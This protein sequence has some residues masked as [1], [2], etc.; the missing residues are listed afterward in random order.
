MRTLL[1]TLF[2]LG[3]LTI[4]AAVPACT[5][6]GIHAGNHHTG[7]YPS[8]AP[9]VPAGSPPGVVI[10]TCTGTTSDATILQRAI[11]SSPFGATIEIGGGTCLLNKG[12]IFLPDRTYTGTSPT[13]T[14]LRQDND[15]N[16]VLASSAYAGNSSST[17]GPVTIRDLTIQCNHSG[18]TNG[19]VVLNW[20]ADVEEVDVHGCGGSGIVDTNTTAGGRAIQ[21]TSVNSRFDNNF[22][23]NSGR[24]GFEVYDSRNS[25]TDGFLDNNLIAHS[26]LD[27]IHLDN[28]AGWNVSGNHLYGNAW[29]GIF[30]NRLY[31]TT[32]SSNYIEG[33]GRR[34]SSGIWCGITATVQGPR[35][36]TIFGNKIFNVSEAGA[37]YIYIRITRTS[38]TGYLTVIGNIIRGD[39]SSD[40][41]LAFDGGSNKLIVASSGNL[42]AQVGTVSSVAR[43][44]TVTGGT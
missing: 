13:G 31:A 39:Q 14:V 8:V 34:Q 10:A 1:R 40:V 24:Y 43:S 4:A 15:M 22:I 42:V 23:S 6:S 3:A 16:Y 12:I 5:S 37:K 11:N 25:V 38:N 36:S 21:G 17:G 33:F 27:G 26:G 7:K 9:S 20:Q 18:G 44:A 35:G 2:A 29:N 30:A 19:L 41:G 32:I 28:A